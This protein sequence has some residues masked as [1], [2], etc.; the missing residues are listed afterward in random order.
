MLAAC[1]PAGSNLEETLSTLRYAASAKNIKTAAVKNEDPAQAKIRELGE[2][3]EQLRKRLEMAEH[4]N[5]GG[6]GGG[7]GGGGVG[8]GLGGR[9]VSSD[10]TDED[11][12]SLLAEL[13]SDLGILSHH[14]FTSTKQVSLLRSHKCYVYHSRDTV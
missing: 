1:S 3:I 10:L 9:L 6:G 13:Q 8:G 2:E 4:S 7:G 12:A 14:G 5:D 11:K